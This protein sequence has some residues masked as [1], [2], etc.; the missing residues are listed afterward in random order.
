MSDG[1]IT[2]SLENR[3]ITTFVST[4]YVSGTV[5]GTIVPETFNLHQNYPN[6]FNPA[7]T[8][9]YELPQAGDATLIVYDLLGQE[10]TR[11]VDGYLGPGYHQT[12]WDGRDDNSREVPSGIYIATLVTPEY[13]TSIKML[14]LK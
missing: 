2:A 3:S 1:S 8:I 12:R 11:L 4:D 13:S 6:P 9:R 5:E 10:V 7:T 14:L